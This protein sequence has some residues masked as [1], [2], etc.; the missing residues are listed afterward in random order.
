MEEHRTHLLNLMIKTIYNEIS[1]EESIE[2]KLACNDDMSLLYEWDALKRDTS[3]L[4]K[5]MFKPPTHVIDD[6]LNYSRED[7]LEVQV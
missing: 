5:A 6:I 1:V 7:K 3:I 2:L 4:P